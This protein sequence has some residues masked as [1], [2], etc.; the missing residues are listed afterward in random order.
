ML[1][2]ETLEKLRRMRLGAMAD[3]LE[4]QQRAPEVH[5]LS[6]EERL[7][8]LVD[9]EW[10]ARRDRRP[11]RLLKEARLR[12]PAA[13]EDIDY[14]TPRGLDK[15]LL[16]TLLG[17]DWLRDG[18]NILLT[19]PTGVGKTFITCALGNVACRQG[20]RTRYYR[21]PRLLGDLEMARADGSYPRFLGRLG[22]VDLLILDDWG[23]A[24][25]T[26][27]EARDLLE[28]IDDRSMSRSTLVSSQLPVENWHST[29][30]DPTVADAILDRLVH[31]A[32]RITLKGESMRKAIADPR[33]KEQGAQG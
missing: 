21:V 14:R 3:A 9:Q 15:S 8:L 25:L 7:G 29:M 33:T 2:Q 11:A 20:F 31:N 12:L 24:P 19:G 5:E 6:F 18:R 4:A 30:G 16:R 10:T 22:R 26:A 17:G 32:Y 13:P 28:V 1:T 23:L 27:P